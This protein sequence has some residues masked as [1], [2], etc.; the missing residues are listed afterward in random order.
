MKKHILSTYGELRKISTMVDL[1]K[2][3]YETSTVE[4]SN[5]DEFMMIGATQET[6]GQENSD[7]DEFF[8]CGP[9]MLTESAENSDSDEFLLEGHTKQTFTQENTD[10]DEF[11]TVCLNDNYLSDFDDILLL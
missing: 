7:P 10:E 1:G 3:T 4:V 8:Y 5:Q 11:L 6:R 9:T 2:T